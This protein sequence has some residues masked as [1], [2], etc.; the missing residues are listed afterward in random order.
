[1]EAIY[2]YLTKKQIRWDEVAEKAYGDAH[3]DGY[4]MDNNPQ[5]A[6]FS[7]LPIGVYVKCPMVLE[8]DAVPSVELLPAWKIDAA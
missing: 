1:M 4:L 6:V 2:Y 7:F 8:A 3:Q 5:L